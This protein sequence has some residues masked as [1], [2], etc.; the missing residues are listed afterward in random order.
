MNILE[1]SVRGEIL[2]FD[3]K[4]GRNI[5]ESRSKKYISQRKLAEMLGI[6]HVVLCYIETGKTKLSVERL[7]QI[8]EVLEIDIKDILGNGGSGS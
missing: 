4:L 6:S 5:I 3:Q 2:T 7:L 8:C 1:K